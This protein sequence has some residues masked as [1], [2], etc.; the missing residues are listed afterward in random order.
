MLAF[1]DFV[2][3]YVLLKDEGMF[4]MHSERAE[5]FDQAVAIAASWI[6]QNGVR[7]M[8]IET[9]VLPN[10]WSSNE[11]GS[12]DGSLRQA[13]GG[14]L[15]YEFSRWHQFVRIWFDNEPGPAPYR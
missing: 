12:R 9:V 1:M 10:M 11:E 2:P 6:K 8:Q 7:V 15:G 5:T 4:S 14:G 13:T 3:R